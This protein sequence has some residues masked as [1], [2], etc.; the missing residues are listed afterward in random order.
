L[1]IPSNPGFSLP[2]SMVEAIEDTLSMED[3]LMIGSLPV[4]CRCLA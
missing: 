3:T 2:P 1:T 4:C